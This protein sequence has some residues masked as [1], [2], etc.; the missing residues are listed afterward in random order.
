MSESLDPPALM[1]G[2]SLS[3]RQQKLL[4]FGPLLV[5]LVV[6]AISGIIWLLVCMREDW[7]FKLRTLEESSN[8]RRAVSEYLASTF[9]AVDRMANRWVIGDGTPA[10]V[11][12]SDARHLMR[13]HPAIDSLAVLNADQTIRWF[14]GQYGQDEPESSFYNDDAHRALTI[15]EAEIT[16]A[17]RASQAITLTSLA[18]KGFLFAT[19]LFI[20]DR[21]QGSIVAEINLAGLLNTVVSHYYENFHFIIR[22]GEDVIFS[23]APAGLDASS[24]TAATEIINRDGLVWRI[25]LIP[26]REVYNH[27]HSTLPTLLLIVGVIVAVLAASITVALKRSHLQRAE[28]ERNSAALN[29]YAAALALAKDRAEAATQAKSQF[30][31]N[32]SHEIRTPMNGVLGM[33]HLLLDTH[34]SVQQLQYI[35]TIDHSARNLLVIINDILDLSKI[36]AQQLHIE[37]IH[38]DVRTAFHETINLFRGLAAN[39]AVELIGTIAGDVPAM[40][41]GDPVRFGQTLANLI[42]N[43]VKFTER[44]YVHA[45]LTWDSASSTIRCV[46]KDSGIG[47]AREKQS[48]MFEK[49]SQGDASVTRKY[50]GTGLGL[51]IIK[52]LVVLMGGEIGFESVEG[53]GSTFWFTLPMP[54]ADE[55]AL[56]PHN[57]LASPERVRIEATAARALI[58]EDHPVNQLLLQKLLGKFGM[59]CI[60]IAEN[61]EVGLSILA[62]NPPYDIIFMDCQMPVMDGY[63]TTRAIRKDE[64]EHPEKRRNHIVA[65]TANAM[66]E[67]RQICFAAGM[68]EYMTKPIDPKKLDQFLS[69]WFI[70]KAQLEAKN[71]SADDG[72]LPIDREALMQLCD[73]PSDLRY[74]LDL[75]F[76]LGGQKIE[77]MRLHRRLEEQA[78]WVGAAHYLKGSAGSMG[79]N[80]LSARC[81]AAEQQKS[82]S[83]E[84]KILLLDA[85]IVEFDR[86]RAYADVLLDEMKETTT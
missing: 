59:G 3:P 28:L 2:P 41:V 25:S 21:Y 83:Y 36:E 37:H 66:L 13:S 38:F 73:G 30:L 16:R 81:L 43:G 84:D 46:I 14:I 56:D 32:M 6:L 24:P 65:M 4:H 57:T 5:F 11:W 48:H 68:D 12:A 9:E 80:A 8:M 67:D 75:F 71:P 31:A 42:G 70:S 86:A 64:E 58:I 85:V 51:A 63:E 26:K 50:G 23:N 27:R 76:T 54:V 15:A 45:T 44:G 60:D 20:D 69:Q 19:P 61:G 72:S 1:P 62:E 22:E 78:Q 55:Q 35:K 18:G 47:I 10:N 33:V 77:E 29:V 34:P 82:A 74:V 53:A 79:M 52:Q 17:H 7:Q 39:K 49:F 40:L